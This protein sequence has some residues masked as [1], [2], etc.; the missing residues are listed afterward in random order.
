ML[1]EQWEWTKIV[2]LWAKQLNNELKLAIKLES[3]RFGWWFS[4]GSSLSHC[5]HVILYYSKNVGQI[6]TAT[7]KVDIPET[8]SGLFLGAWYQH[9]PSKWLTLE[10]MIAAVPLTTAIIIQA[11]DE[12]NLPSITAKLQQQKSWQIT[13]STHSNCLSR[14]CSI[15]QLC[16]KNCI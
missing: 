8:K 6:T 13:C 14:H 5:C 9:I 12:H 7:S 15:V 10:R 3:S 16:M 2:K 11:K 4:I 1:W